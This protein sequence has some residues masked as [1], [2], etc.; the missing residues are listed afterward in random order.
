[1]PGT[2]SV[3][4]S[5]AGQIARGGGGGSA[6]TAS[7]SSSCKRYGRGRAA[8][9]PACAFHSASFSARR[10]LC[11]HHPAFSDFLRLSDFEAFLHNF[12]HVSLCC[13]CPTYFVHVLLLCTFPAHSCVCTTPLL[14][15]SQNSLNLKHSPTSSLMSHYFAAA[16]PNLVDLL[17]FCSFPQNIHRGHFSHFA[18][19]THSL[20]TCPPVRCFPPRFHTCHTNLR[21]GF[22]TCSPIFPTCSHT[23]PPICPVR[24]EG[25][26]PDQS[27]IKYSSMLSSLLVP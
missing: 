4:M 2:R 10:S 9:A 12:I 18:A 20:C 15:L 14:Q 7:R 23:C 8:V 3:G 21:T 22:C 25:D 1:M 24:P 16:P 27:L 5:S 11:V 19:P 26:S 17:L 13:S 6:C